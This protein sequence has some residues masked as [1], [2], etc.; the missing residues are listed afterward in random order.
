MFKKNIQI[1]KGA[2]L[3]MSISMALGQNVYADGFYTIIGP[4]G[5]PMIVP[6]RDNLQQ[7]KSQVKNIES[8]PTVPS[9]IIANKVEVPVT[10]SNSQNKYNHSDATDTRKIQKIES[11]IVE[12]KVESEKVTP[13]E[14]QLFQESNSVQTSASK[15]IKTTNSDKKIKDSRTVNTVQDVKYVTNIYNNQK[16]GFTKIDGESYVNNEYLEDQEFNLEGKK[17]FYIMPDGS[18]RLETVERKKG[19]SRSMLDR[20][21]NRPTESGK[22][23]TL[24]SN[25]VRLSAEDLALAFEEDRCFVNDYTKSIKK[26]SP[27][28][29]I[30]LWPRKPLKEKFEYELIELDNP[31]RYVQVDSYASSNNRPVYYWPLIIFLDKKGCIQEGVSGFKNEALLG[32]AFRH[33]AI[34]G[35]LRVPETAH[36]IMMTPLASAVDVPEQELSNQGQ[37]KISVIQ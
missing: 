6:K 22:A 28:K 21:M 11:A 31:I 14:S 24:S 7:S 36:Y 5:R 30:G 10:L 26:L 17:R 35:V 32:T 3:I 20:I 13:V 33:A 23:I 18:G 19:V 16:D 4:D 12:Q 1:S 2:M 37:I 34:Q 9:K 27:K 8:A 25:Y 15:E 29:E